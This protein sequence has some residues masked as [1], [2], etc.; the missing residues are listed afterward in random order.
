MPL[1]Q[2]PTLTQPDMDFKTLASIRLDYLIDYN[3]KGIDGEHYK[4]NRLA[5]KK[6][7]KTDLS[8]LKLGF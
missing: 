3:T 5:I 4:K 8:G 7:L 2:Y 1:V 6:W